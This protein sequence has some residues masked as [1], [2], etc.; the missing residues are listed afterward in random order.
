MAKIDPTA[1]PSPLVATLSPV[2]RAVQVGG[3]A[4]TRATIRNTGTEPAI[5]VGI[6]LPSGI[7]A[8]LVGPLSFVYQALDASGMLTGTLNTPVTIPPG[9]CLR[10]HQHPTCPHRARAQHPPAFGN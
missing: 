5:D 4:T 2:S 9:L 3:F 10:W 6:A 8:G 7:G 1:L